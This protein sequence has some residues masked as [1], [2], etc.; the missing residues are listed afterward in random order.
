VPGVRWHVGLT[1]FKLWVISEF[2]GYA[3][4]QPLSQRTHLGRSSKAAA[5]KKLLEVDDADEEEEDDGDDAASSGQ[6]HCN[7][8]HTPCILHATQDS[9]VMIVQM[10]RQPL[11]QVMTAATAA[12]MHDASA[13]LELL[14][15]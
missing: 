7:V 12:A 11:V 6:Q 4:T 13:C 5:Q 10:P 15:R 9:C 8:L 3:G 2:D 1:A 14:Y